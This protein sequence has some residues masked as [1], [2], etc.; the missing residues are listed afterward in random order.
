MIKEGFLFSLSTNDKKEGHLSLW[1]KSLSLFSDLLNGHH[2]VILAYC[3]LMPTYDG[4]QKALALY[5]KW[6]STVFRFGG[7]IFFSMP[8]YGGQIFSRYFSLQ[9]LLRFS[10]A[11]LWRAEAFPP[12]SSDPITGY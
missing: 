3:I 1:K 4:N 8:T 7:I 5:W 9:D 10:D 2:W 6:S 11:H 12:F